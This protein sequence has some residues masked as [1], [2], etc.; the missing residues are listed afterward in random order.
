VYLCGHY[1]PVPGFTIAEI[2]FWS[3]MYE[4]RTNP[5]SDDE[6]AARLGVD[7]QLQGLIG[8]WNHIAPYIDGPRWAAFAP[9]ADV[10]VPLPRTAA[11][12][13]AFSSWALNL[14][15]FVP[16]LHA[17]RLTKR[18]KQLV[19]VYAP[20]GSGK[21]WLCRRSTT[22]GDIDALAAPIGLDKP[23]YGKGLERLSKRHLFMVLVLRKAILEGYV[24]LFGQWDPADLL[25]A[26]AGMDINL[27]IKYFDP[28]EEIRVTRLQKRG[29]D[30]ESIQHRRE[31]W[32]TDA[33]FITDW[34]QL[35]ADLPK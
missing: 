26:A 30:A 29:W 9:V 27:H 4:S 17:R 14:A 28:G 18:L 22:W 23:K 1:E 13:W 25:N 5:K 8:S 31:R 35:V 6:L 19:Y 7:P 11:S 16:D 20:N 24:V 21:T 12:N 10:H 33:D 34:R 2:S 3:D 15:S 32:I